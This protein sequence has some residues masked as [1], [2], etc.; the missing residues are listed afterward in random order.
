MFPVPVIMNDT[1]YTIPK[2]CNVRINKGRVVGEKKGKLY[3]VS[4]LLIPSF[5][6][7][8]LSS[9]S[10]LSKD[11]SRIKPYLQRAQKKRWA[12]FSS[13]PI[14]LPLRLKDYILL[15]LSLAFFFSPCGVPSLC[16]LKSSRVKMTSGARSVQPDTCLMAMVAQCQLSVMYPR[17]L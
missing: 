9:V 4:V 13:D 12:P 2:A 6:V 1:N 15:L 10:V 5:I 11:P 7:T 3:S 8:F 14:L 17:L 16:S